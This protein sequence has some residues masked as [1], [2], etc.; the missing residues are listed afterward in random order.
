MSKHYKPIPFDCYLC[1]RA[2]RESG[3][4]VHMRCLICQDC[5]D[6]ITAKGRYWCYKG[7]HIV[8]LLNKS[9]KCPDCVSKINR[10]YSMP[11]VVI[12]DGWVRTYDWAMMIG[13]PHSTV[14]QRIRHGWKPE[15]KK[16]GCHYWFNPN[17]TPPPYNP[18]PPKKSK[19]IPLPEGMILVY[20]A[21]R[22]T[23][24]PVQ[25]IKRW[26]CQGWPGVEAKRIKGRWVLS[27]LPEYPPPPPDRRK[28]RYTK[29]DQPLDTPD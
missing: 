9:R 3:K 13:I 4:R 28:Y 24:I 7:K 15:Y 17:Q 14:R 16:L 2:G 29:P 20:D 18:R 25:T 6:A 21:S 5:M 8:D 11:G 27:D 1:V 22:R 26:I 12:P 10:K 23:K 19:R